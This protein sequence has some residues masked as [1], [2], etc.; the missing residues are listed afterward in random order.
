MRGEGNAGR[1]YMK[2]LDKHKVD[3]IIC[4]N[5]ELYLDACE[6]FIRHLRVPEGILVNIIVIRNA[7]S[8]TVA[9]QEAMDSSDA[10]YKVYLH[11]DTFI[12]NPDFIP[13]F[14]RIFESHEELG[15]L[16]VIGATRL[17]R[18]GS[19]YGNW[20]LGS[21]LICTSEVT[22][23][24]QKAEARE[25]PQESAFAYAEAVDGMLMITQYD[26]TWRSDILQGFDYYDAS[27]AMEYRRRGYRCGVINSG[28]DPW[29]IHDCGYVTPAHIMEQKINFC[30][31]YTAE[32]FIYNVA[33]L[34]AQRIAIWKDV[35]QMVRSLKIMFDQGKYEDVKYLIGGLKKIGILNTEVSYLS[36]LIQIKEEEEKNG[37]RIL[38]KEERSANELIQWYIKIKLLLWEVTYDIDPGVAVTLKK[39]VASEQV[40]A[41]M[42]KTVAQHSLYDPEVTV[43]KLKY[44]KGK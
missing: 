4:Y 26:V 21:T 19:I 3:F 35:P 8:I 29:T 7:K 37:Q 33:D 17:N 34:E 39:S 22:G 28:R 10:R 1:D 18:N 16:G 15:L 5:N 41:D 31:E 27:C 42:V 13:G 32:G 30:R 36:Q 44:Y 38:L 6:K 14:I 23:I 24:N 12:L 25:I 20:D 9:Y 43:E 11:Q 2:N 40:S